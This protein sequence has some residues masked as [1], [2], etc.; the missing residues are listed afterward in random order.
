MP[1]R[2]SVKSEVTKKTRAEV[3]DAYDTLKARRDEIAAEAPTDRKV[4][5]VIRAAEA[6]LVK[7]SSGYTVENIVKGIAELNLHVG[8]ALTELAEKMTAEARKLE[9]IQ[10]AIEVETRRLEE[11]RDIKIAEDSLALLM[12]E[13][14]AKKQAFEEETAQK[15]ESFRRRIQELQDEWKKE[16]ALH[17]AAVKERDEKIEKDRKREKEDHEYNLALARKKDKDEY[18]QQKAALQRALK[19]ERAAH[20][21]EFADREARLAASEG[22]LADLRK[23][24]EAFQDTLDKAVKEA[25]KRAAA[26]AQSKAETTAKLLAKEVE[27]ERKLQELK[28]ANLQETLQKQSAQIESLAQQLAEANSQV[29]HIAAK[30]IEGASGAR[31]LTTVQ[32]IALEQ[33]K[34]IKSQK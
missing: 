27:G 34:Q 23:K 1:P 18:E 21:K 33:A 10:G 29:Q 19:E 6:E 17:E 2:R 20:E 30:A 22:E 3:I 31:T 8:K 12:A 4:E 13:N 16:Q 32:E 11:V 7:R 24:V 26:E 14:E 15:E 9:D 28:I 25:E 5:E